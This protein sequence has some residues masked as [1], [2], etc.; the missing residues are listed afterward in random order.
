[1]ALTVLMPR[2]SN[3]QTAS[4][5]W[6]TP[7][8]DGKDYARYIQEATAL[9]VAGKAFNFGDWCQLDTGESTV[10]RTIDTTVGPP[11]EFVVFT[12][13]AYVFTDNK[14]RGLC[15]DRSSL[16]TSMEVM[17]RFKAR[18]ASALQDFHT[19][20]QAK[21]SEQERRDREAEDI[22]RFLRVPTTQDVSRQHAPVAPSEDELAHRRAMEQQQRD[23]QRH[24]DERHA[25]EITHTLLGGSH[26]P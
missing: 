10:D 26:Y 19:Q 2:I 11:Q 21:M 17:L 14:Q 18:S 24:E 13:T 1:M 7:P 12:Y 4:A 9:N 15:P 25:A 16:V 8:T 20:E 6:W 3:A 5:S 23:D 22:R